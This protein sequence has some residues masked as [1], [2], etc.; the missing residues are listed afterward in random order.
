MK[1]A[2]VI[3][4]LLS[5]TLK[6][7]AYQLKDGTGRPH[8]IEEYENSAMELEDVKS[9]S[10]VIE[11]KKLKCGKK[12]TL[13]KADLQFS[14][15]TKNLK[16]IVFQSPDYEKKPKYPK[17]ANCQSVL[18]IPKETTLFVEWID[19]DIE[20]PKKDKCKGDYL[21]IKG[22]GG[23]KFYCGELSGSKLIEMGPWGKG[24]KKIEISFRSDNDG[25]RGHGVKL[26][27]YTK[28]MRISFN[29]TKNSSF[30]TKLYQF[31]FMHPKISQ[32]ISII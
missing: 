23:A 26:Y 16:A 20:N 14:N 1:L 25:K 9:V 2:T 3:I 17:K 29:Y 27:L 10:N 32:N 18:E 8:S 7:I 22:P 12:L 24:P 4:I 21:R 31:G 11:M 5:T 30:N 15:Q 28:S 19:M 13:F 6:N